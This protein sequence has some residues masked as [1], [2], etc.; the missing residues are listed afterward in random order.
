MSPIRIRSLSLAT[1]AALAFAPAAFAQDGST[2]P[3]PATTGKRFAVVAGYAH[4][5]PKSDPGAVLGSEAD[6]DGGGAPTL[7]GSWYVNDNV[8]VELWDHGHPLALD[9]GLGGR[10][11]MW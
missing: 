6:L 2:E 11:L 1:A 4:L 8:A 7:S 3:T 5:V 9:A 10:L